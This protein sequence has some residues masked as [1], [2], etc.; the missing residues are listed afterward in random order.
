[1][2]LIGALVLLAGCVAAPEDARETPA[3]DAAGDDATGEPPVAEASNDTTDRTD[4]PAWNGTWNGT[5]RWNGTEPWNGTANGTQMP[6]PEGEAQRIER[7]FELRVSTLPRAQGVPAED[8]LLVYA[9]N[10]TRLEGGTATLTWTSTPLAP[11]LQAA[12]ASSF[13]ME[14]NATTGPSPLLLGLPRM[15]LQSTSPPPPFFA[16]EIP[17]SSAWLRVTVPDGDVAPSVTVT[18]ALAMDLV[19]GPLEF[20]VGGCDAAT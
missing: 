11:D 1:M 5:G 15:T 13:S 12:F 8:C 4:P 20:E 14:R 17:L 7:T 6:G 2:L 19:G 10:V 16:T 3:G 18:L 9:R